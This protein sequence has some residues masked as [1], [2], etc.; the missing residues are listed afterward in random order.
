MPKYIYSDFIPIYEEGEGIA[1]TPG[2]RYEVLDEFNYRNGG[3]ECQ[4]SVRDDK[5]ILRGPIN[6]GWPCAFLNYKF[7]TVVIEEL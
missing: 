6:V 7:W 5:G 1:F 3:K 2:K 4:V